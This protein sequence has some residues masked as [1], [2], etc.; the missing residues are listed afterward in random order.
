METSNSTRGR[1]IFCKSDYCFVSVKEN[2]MFCYKKM[3]K[4]LYKQSQ[5]LKELMLNNNKSNN[6]KNFIK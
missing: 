6:T 2:M 1:I 5:G 4:Y 3:A